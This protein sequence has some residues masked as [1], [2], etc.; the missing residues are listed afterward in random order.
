MFSVG[1]VPVPNQRMPVSLKDLHF[2][3]VPVLVRSLILS[4]L[5]A[6]DIDSLAFFARPIFGLVIRG[7]DTT[8]VFLWRQE[9]QVH[10]FEDTKVC[11][12]GTWGARVLFH[13]HLM[14]LADIEFRTEI[15]FIAIP[16]TIIGLSTW[17]LRNMSLYLFIPHAIIWRWAN[18]LV[19]RA[20]SLP[21]P[22]F[23][24]F[25]PQ[26][27]EPAFVSSREFLKTL[28]YR[29]GLYMPLRP[30]GNT[31]SCTFV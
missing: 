7:T 23:H 19:P 25:L 24:Q 16:P 14:H 3:L 8:H 22:L 29:L 10:T 20:F 9:W 27:S 21:T 6:S 15:F 4:H 2:L 26:S 11:C 1:T 30:E 18:I 12:I 28:T 31:V 13:K 17:E 5:C